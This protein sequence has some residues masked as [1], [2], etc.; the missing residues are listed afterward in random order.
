MLSA[1]R[2]RATV[3]IGRQ[4]DLT[5]DIAKLQQS[6]SSTKRLSKASDD[7]AAATRISE[8]RQVQADE[9]VWKNNINTGASVA[10]AVDNRLGGI[11]DV[12]NRAKEL[13]LRGRNDSTSPSDR[14]AIALSL[15]ELA[16]DLDSSATATDSSGNALFPTDPAFGIPVS[17][18]LSLPATVTRSDVF[19]NIPTADG[20]QSLQQ[21]LRGA[22]DAIVNTNL[23]QRA[24][25]VAASVAAVDNGIAH[26][27][28]VRTD[29]GIRAARFDEARDSLET[30]V[31]Q[32]KEER[33]VL[34]DTD[35]T[36]A[37]STIQAKQLSLQAAQTVYAQTMKSTLFDL[38]G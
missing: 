9:L 24:T 5:S 26:V 19:D 2:Y 37:L 36:Y 25:D 38:I 31:E 8:L 33:S 18:T 29:Q 30:R 6:I 22:A 1:T 3:E 28:A 17:E 35:L 13:I 14:Q 10:A 4:N 34:E 21:M 20:P 23:T 27:I 32:H 7:P 15:R 11:G 16:T 12:L